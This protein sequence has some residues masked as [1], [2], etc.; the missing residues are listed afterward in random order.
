MT[1]QNK[2][3]T[4]AFYEGFRH[5]TTIQLRFKDV[6]SMGHVNNANHLTYFETARMYYFNEVITKENN[7]QK[8]GFI[9][10]S[11]TINYILPVYLQNEISVFTRCSRIGN[12]SFDLEYALVKKTADGY[13]L[14]AKGKSVIVC[15]D[16]VLKKSIPVNPEWI[17]KI[18]AH[19]DF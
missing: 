3:K 5:Q 14:L 13:T 17:E 7:W 12:K 9:L 15:Y 1:L 6:D 18:K 11:V 16:Y 19:D 8:T 2:E 10:A 4:D